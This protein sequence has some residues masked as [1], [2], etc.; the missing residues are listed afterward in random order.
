MPPIQDYGVRAN[1]KTEALINLLLDAS[2][3]AEMSLQRPIRPLIQ[4]RPQPPRPDTVQLP[5]RSTSRISSRSTV[6]RGSVIIHDI[7]DRNGQQ[8]TSRSSQERNAKPIRLPSSQLPRR[9]ARETQYRLGVGRP[10]VAGGKG[11][12]AVTKSVNVSQRSRRLKNSTTLQPSEATIV[13]GMK[14]EFVVSYTFDFLTL[15]QNPSQKSGSQI[16]TVSQLSCSP[17]RSEYVDE[18][19]EKHSTGNSPPTDEPCQQTQPPL[20]THMSGEL[21]ESAVSEAVS[22]CAIVQF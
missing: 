17:A 7:N 16:H 21:V 18:I 13:E 22:T 9:K 19:A 12:R 3:S 10:I 6:R 2:R 1:L 5:V 14:A 11:A 15:W 4:T 20:G 8:S